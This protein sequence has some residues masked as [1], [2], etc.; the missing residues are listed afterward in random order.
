MSEP[1]NIIRN[2]MLSLLDKAPIGILIFNAE[3]QVEY[4]NE[5]FHQFGTLYNFKTSGILGKNLLNDEIFAGTSFNEELNNLKEGFAFE[6]EIKNFSSSNGKINLIVKA[7][8]LEN[9]GIFNGGIIILEDLK[10]IEKDTE[11]QLYYD[12]VRKMLNN[13][14]D[15]L[16]I[17]DSEGIVQYSLGRK[18]DTLNLPAEKTPSFEITQIFSPGA[19]KDFVE[20]L[21]IVKLKRRPEILNLELSVNSV[22]N[23]YECKIE[24]TLNKR[25]QIQFIFFSFSDITEIIEKKKKL[26]EEVAELKQYQVITEVVTDAVFAVDLDGKITFWNKA[27]EILFNYSKSEIFGKSFTKVPGFFGSDYFTRIKDEI[28]KNGNWESDFVFIN[29]LNKKSIILAKFSLIGDNN[30]TIVILCSDITKRAK[31][32]KQLRTSEE[33][34]RSIVTHAAELI[35]TIDPEGVIT[36][37]NKMFIT[38]LEFS[39]EEILFKNIKDLISPEYL[40]QNGFELKNFSEEENTGSE[41]PVISKSGRKIYLSAKFSPIYYGRTLRYFYGFFTDITRKKD[42]QKELL[43]FQ[44]IFDASIDGMAV[45]SG[46]KILLANNSLAEEFGYNS[47]DEM[48]DK[49]LDELINQDDLNKIKEFI[50]SEEFNNKEKQHYEILG[51]RKNGTNFFAEVSIASF[52]TEAVN[53]MVLIIRDITERKRSQQAIRESEEKYRSITENIDDFLFTF[54]Q[55]YSTLRPTF[56]TASVEKVT[57][58]SQLEF[59]GDPKLILKIIHPDDFNSIKKHIKVF[60]RSRIQL[61][62]EIEFRILNKQGNV[63]WIRAKL[64]FKRNSKGEIQ[65]MYGLVTD[66]S[67][68]KKAE[69]EL[70]KSTQKLVKLNETKDRFISIIS[71]DLRTPFSSILGFTDLLLSDDSLDEKERNQYVRFIQES[72][73][74]MLSLVN[75]LL[76]WTRLQTG[77]IS[78]EP[79]KIKAEN[80]IQNSF[81]AMSGVAFQKNIDLINYVSE[82]EVIYV[83]KS[84][85]LQVFNNLISNAIKFTNIGGKIEIF[86]E[87]SSQLRFLQFCI[88]DSGIGIKEEN[89]G[90]LFNVDTKFTSEGTAGEKGSGLGLSLVKEIIEK[91]SGKIWVKSEYGKGTYFYFTLPVASPNILLVDDNKTDRLL[92]S[93]IIKNIT[94]D[95]NVEIAS[96]GKEAFDIITTSPPALVITDHIMP[97]MNGYEM[98]QELQKTEMKGMP[99]IIVL[100]HDVDRNAIFD[101]NNLGIKYVFQKPVDLNSFKQAVVKSLR[102]GITAN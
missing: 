44:S 52:K 19:R 65:K 39:E 87:P 45:E 59:L 21:N 101:Y 56:F 91:H 12:Y 60:L 2:E 7:S 47:P 1:Q 55:N 66:I 85:L 28:E 78:F 79:E 40:E 29:R 10:I 33:K 16:F 88:K 86:A 58:Y 73:K 67:L 24:P 49:N 89:L 94:P 61:T 13:M 43:I 76:D 92:Y 63:A 3:W 31:V 14:N 72:S 9:K 100:S 23:I 84:L 54:E 97:N 36:Y 70:R 18:I 82:N 27:A 34:Y 69:N 57:G 62:E 95:Y 22:K 25:G 74:S 77:R 11:N 46:G 102:L 42:A 81:N 75:S 96:D 6:K 38:T 53:H 68:R 51:K 41:F 80:I 26:E 8:P 30:D 32:E 37:A 20:H 17:T 71:H 4:A 90:K 35:C 50:K 48:F 15:F 64:N 5:N 98:I 93:K 83:D 99:P